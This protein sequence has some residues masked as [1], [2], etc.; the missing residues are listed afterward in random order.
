MEKNFP[1][2]LAFCMVLTTAI[3]VVFL[4]KN[5]YF[6]NPVY[7]KYLSLILIIICAA[8]LICINFRRIFKLK[9]QGIFRILLNT[10]NPQKTII[11]IGISAFLIFTFL[12]VKRHINLDTAMFDLGLEQQVVMNTAGGRLMESGIETGNYLGDHFSLVTLPIALVY[13]ILPGTL[14]LF[15]LQNLAIVI[16][17]AGVYVLAKKIL[18]KTSWAFIF[19]LIFLS[20]TGI[21]GLYLFDYH[22]VAFALPLLVWGIYFFFAKKIK[23][24]FLLLV[25]AAFCKEDIGIYVSMLGI[26]LAVKYHEK[27]GWILAVFGIV[28]SLLALFVFIPYF[29]GGE[30]DTLARYSW[31]GNSFPEM[32][33]TVIQKPLYVI[34]TIFSL[35]KLSYLVKMA[36]PFFFIFLLAPAESLVLLPSLFLNLF[37]SSIFQ[38]SGLY[39]YDVAVSAGIFFAGICGLQNLL[40]FFAQHYPLQQ[41][42][43]LQRKLLTLIFIINIFLLVVHPAFKTL[44]RPL[45]R[46]NDYVFLQELQQRIP[47]D[48]TVSLSN[49]PG[50]QFGNF[51]H[52]QLFDDNTFQYAKPPDLVIIDKLAG[53]DDYARIKTGELLGSGY[54]LFQENNSFIILINREKHLLKRPLY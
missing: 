4:I 41:Q 40:K 37:S 34:S 19:F 23:Y 50:G 31:L 53:Y 25:L 52:I 27:K 32:L 17:A 5:Y 7:S 12:A 14:T 9:V 10:I 1:G 13:K 47:Q 6:Y 30:S 42:Q 44:L 16:A 3:L 28:F 46:Y 26:L 48:F 15:V 20:Y 35:M 2:F 38:N 21:S 43:I 33:Q 22:P 29:R 36:L 8:G 54:C 51:E 11:I 45:S 39:H 24:S 49:I 18:Q